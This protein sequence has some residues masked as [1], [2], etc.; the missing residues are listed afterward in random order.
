MGYIQA[1]RETWNNRDDSP[2]LKA[3]WHQRLIDWRKGEAVVRV[4]HP[5]RLDRARSVGFKAKEGYIVV[6]V[7]LPRGGRL[8]KK[9]KGGRKPTKMR[10]K[11]ILDMSYQTVA[12]RRANKRYL[13]C[14]VLN[15]Y[16][17]A[18][19]GKHYWYEV[20]LVDRVQ[21]SKYPGMEWLADDSNKGR[22]YRGLTMSARK[23]RGL[24]RKGKG[25]EKLRP[26]RRS[27]WLR[28]GKQKYVFATKRH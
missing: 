14:E 24:T 15:S 27:N 5:V 7:R 6:R 12:E 10:R 26:S 23:T 3:I 2:E 20:I 18:Q 13:N 1:I 19:D 22:I 4:D 17:L 21:V 25:A 11:L 9:F 8:R 16:F 28:R